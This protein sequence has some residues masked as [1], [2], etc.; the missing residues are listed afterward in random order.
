MKILILIDSLEQGGAET[1][2]ELLCS[3]L[4]KLGVDVFVASAGGAVAKR[5]KRAG[6]KQIYL[7]PYDVHWQKERE[8]ALSP[9][10]SFGVSCN[11]LKRIVRR[12]RPDIVHAHT[13]KTAL[14]AH[15]ICKREKIPLITTAHAMFSMIAPLNFLPWGDGTIAVSEDIRDH[16]IT[17]SLFP[18][19][20]IKIINNGVLIEEETQNQ[21]IMC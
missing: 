15:I 16:I 12:E 3:H 21:N 18:P 14:L 1:H 17:K 8:S 11:V 5:M 6:I 19:T 9:I 7:P 2:V 20:N 13:R 10:V 4:Q